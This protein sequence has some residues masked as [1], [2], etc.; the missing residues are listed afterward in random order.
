[1]EGEGNSIF[2]KASM[3]MSMSMLMKLQDRP[4]AL[5]STK[6]LKH[7][8]SDHS[9]PLKYQQH[10]S[11]VEEL[12]KYMSSVP[13]YLQLLDRGG[14]SNQEKALNV[15]VLNWSHLQT[16][17]N[18]PINPPSSTQVTKTSINTDKTSESSDVLPVNCKPRSRSPLR[19]MLDPLLRQ[20]TWNK[21]KQEAPSRVNIAVEAKP[22]ASAAALDVTAA[23][24]TTRAL[25]RVAWKNGYPLYTFSMNNTD[26]LAATRRKPLFGD[27]E[28]TYTFYYVHQIPNKTKRQ[29]M[30]SNVVGKMNVKLKNDHQISSREF[31]LV[32]SQLRP[33]SPLQPT[34]FIHDAQ[35]A[36][37]VIEKCQ[38][39]A[40]SS[41]TDMLSSCSSSNS[42]GGGGGV[43]NLEDEEEANKPYRSVVVILPNHVHG[44]SEHGPGT[45]SSLIDRWRSGGFCDCG[46]WDL[47]CPLT[48][49][50]EKAQK[51]GSQLFIQV[52]LPTYQN[53][54][55]LFTHMIV[56]THSC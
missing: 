25:L 26:I 9:T 45:P 10:G 42:C 11:R 12:V 31:I 21:T 1:M 14:S 50:T 54:V 28:C 35:L 33:S 41:N 23:A 4:T 18:A 22:P 55:F 37:V 15:G 53:P 24:A 32:G 49:L 3:S 17:K 8:S 13:A 29:T 51:S 19:R 56:K 27:F 52:K 48:I 30:L 16:Y 38:K 46:G 43:H 39:R 2:P 47:G 40:E 44:S 6:S 7:S 20:K 34:Y 5:K 36:A